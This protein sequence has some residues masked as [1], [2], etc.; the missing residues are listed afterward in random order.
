MSAMDSNRGSG[1]VESSL[2]ALYPCAKLGLSDRMEAWGM[3]GLG[4]GELTIEE[5]GG[6][7]PS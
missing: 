7:P 1:T 5:R 3:V 2:T 6:T 4:T